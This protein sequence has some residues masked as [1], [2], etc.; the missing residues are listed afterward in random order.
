MAGSAEEPE[1]SGD[2]RPREL[3][4]RRNPCRSHS[5]WVGTNWCSQAEAG[6]APLQEGGEVMD[7]PALAQC[8]LKRSQ[9]AKEESVACESPESIAYWGGIAW[10]FAEAG[11]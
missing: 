9:E 6:R 10:A 11:R 5:Y 8:L 3:R 7:G 2:D 4:V 1:L